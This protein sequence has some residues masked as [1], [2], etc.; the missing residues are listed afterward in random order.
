MILRQDVLA[1]YERVLTRPGP[2]RRLLHRVPWTLDGHG[3][4]VE[5]LVRSLAHDARRLMELEPAPRFSIVTPLFE[6]P[7]RYLEEAI[8]S[9]RLQSWQRWELLLVD[10]G[11]ARRD[12]LEA[13]RAAAARDPRVRLEVLPRRGGISAARNAALALAEGDWV[14]FLDHD[15]VLHPSALGHFAARVAGDPRLDLLF[16]NEAKLDPTSTR[17][18]EF[19][20]KPDLDAFTLLRVNYV[21]HP[22]LV[23]RALLEGLRARDGRVFRGEWDG[24]EDHD[25]LLRLALSHAPPRSAHLPLFLYY[26]RRA[27]TSTATSMATK[28][29]AAVRALEMVRSHLVQRLGEGGFELD[30]P[31]SPRGNTRLSVRPRLPKGTTR[32]RL[33][34]IVPF[35]DQVDVTLR[36]LA[37]L[38]RQAC[39]G[40]DVRV[41][42]VDNGSVEAETGARLG[43][44]IAA[45]RRLE[46][47][48]LRDDGAFNFARINNDA[49]RARAGDRDLLLFLNNDVELVSTDCLETMAAH[50]LSDPT[51]GFVGLRLMYPDGR[52]VQHGGVVVVVGFTG[53]G[54]YSVGHA[55]DES[56]FVHD[57]HVVMGVT[58][59]CAMTRRATWERLGG[60]D[61]RLFPNGFGDVDISL[62][63][64]ELGLRNHYFGTL[65]GV[66]HEGLTR[67][68]TCE[69]AEIAALHERHGATLARWRLRQLAFGLQP[70]WATKTVDMRAPDGPKPPLRHRIADRLNEGLRRALGGWHG[71]LKASLERSAAARRR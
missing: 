29:D 50:L 9:C 20:S 68:R 40:L 63:A 28:P 65:V 48:L 19:L 25:L 33:A 7:P 12:H 55:Q 3:Q 17:I 31:G 22:L 21:A 49:V 69:D 67:G 11:S 58:F 10:D 16:S 47:D 26:W 13:A 52:S 53:A 37:S 46:Y 61:E 51:C 59:A 18:T 32:P 62:R 64:L 41:V 1:S 30:P 15:D 6:T 8:A 23:R 44:W 2:E 71:V 36:A 24:A 56:E 45:P 60:L 35:R 38:E 34:V 5:G 43:A 39:D 54:Y 42:L 57:E 4:P 27:E 70:R 66:H 14:L